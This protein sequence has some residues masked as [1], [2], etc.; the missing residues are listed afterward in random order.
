MYQFGLRNS[1]S[2][3]L[4]ILTSYVSFDDL[5]CKE[6]SK[7][8]CKNS[9]ILLNLLHFFIPN[10]NQRCGGWEAETCVYVR[11]R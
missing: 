7:L 6:K 2:V 1:Q 4:S 11:E 8:C 9:I 5:C 10:Q 3:V